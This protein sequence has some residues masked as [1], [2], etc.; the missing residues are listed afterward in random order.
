MR[1]AAPP[2]RGALIG[3]G[4]VSQFHLESWSRVPDARL[5][6]LC[7]MDRVRLEQASG[8]APEARCYTEAAELFDQEEE[9]DFVEICTRPDSHRELVELAARHGTHILCQK[10][11]A[12]VRSDFRAMIEACITTGVR[13]M[14]HENW[15]FRPWYRAF[16]AEID[17]GVIG[18]PIR[19][20]IAH[21]DTRALRPD[22]FAPQP[23]LATMPRMILMDMGCHL[24]DTA[25]YLIGEIQ[26]VSA[27]I[28][29]F[30]KS[31]LGE[32]LAML[33]VYFA[34]GTLGWIDLSWCASPDL[35]RPEWAL[36]QTVAEGTGGTLRLLTDGSLE[37]TSPTGKRERK[38]IALPPDDQVYRDGFVAAQRHFI[39][40]LL[41]GAEHETRASDNLK[42]MDVVWTAYR[43]AEEGRTLSV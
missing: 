11:A 2:L 27:S 3:C 17:A 43:S 37:W 23:Y 26:T 13:L 15:R 33:A 7:D 20:R 18:R 39:E 5:V 40:G 28:G 9:L 16:R 32:D 29:R 12:L 21:H 36:H 19:L 4:Y 24:I 1:S 38:T 35:A 14:I 30:G 31:S 41:S 22:G 34:G 25:R 42:T 6:A 8:R 10:P